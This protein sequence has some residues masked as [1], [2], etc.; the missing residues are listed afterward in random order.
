[1]LGWSEAHLKLGIKTFVH[2]SLG[3][4]TNQMVNLASFFISS[5]PLGMGANLTRSEL[6]VSILFLLI[7]L[8]CSTHWLM[9]GLTMLF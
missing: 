2:H 3:Q 8:A 9:F 7:S 1:M 6:E 5:I 4:T